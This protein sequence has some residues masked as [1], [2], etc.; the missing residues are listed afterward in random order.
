[1]G[2]GSIALTIAASSPCP[3]D[4]VAGRREFSEKLSFPGAT[5]IHF[6]VTD[7]RDIGGH[8]DFVLHQDADACTAKFG[9]EPEHLADDVLASARLEVVSIWPAYI[10]C[11]HN[12]DG[13]AR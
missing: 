1:M 13:E 7:P 10:V 8:L 9:G 6:C 11:R 3:I 12:D 4:G 2:S 5:V